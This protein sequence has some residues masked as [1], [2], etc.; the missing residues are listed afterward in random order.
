MR[1]KGGGG[2]PRARQA[3]PR[4]LGIVGGVVLVAVIAIVLALVLGSGGGS[5]NSGGSGTVTQAD[6]ADL[7]AKGN[8][9]SPVALD[10]APDANNLFSLTALNPYLSGVTPARTAV[11]PPTLTSTSSFDFSTG[12]NGFPSPYTSGASN[13]AAVWTGTFTAG[14]STLACG[15]CHGA[16]PPASSGHPA[17]SSALTGCATCHPKTV[18]ADGTIDVAGGFHVNGTVEVDST[19]MTCSSCHGTSGRTGTDPFIAAAPPS[20][21]HGETA[22]T[23]RALR[24]GSRGRP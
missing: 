14:T 22:T 18:K 12:G 2:A 13:F 19:A 7:P 11:A 6:L 20:G 23:T 15:S 4:V 21:T 9:S 17:V 24:P 5:G 8:S 3:S 10:G 1:S 16:P